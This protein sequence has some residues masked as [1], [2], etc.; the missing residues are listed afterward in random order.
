MFGSC[1]IQLSIMR[2]CFHMSRHVKGVYESIES[3]FRIRNMSELLFHMRAN[4]AK[5]IIELSQKVDNIR[6]VLGM[7]Q[8]C[9]THND[10]VIEN[11]MQLC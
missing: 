5:R 7:I 4:G 9:T 2:L 1:V 6:F 11:V 3:N 10:Y 8:C